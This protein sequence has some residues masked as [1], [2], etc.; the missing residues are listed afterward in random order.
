MSITIL[1]IIATGALS[2]MAFS[3]HQLI[4]NLVFY[5]YRIWRDKEWHR[6]VSCSFIHADMGHLFFNMF[7]L[8][9]FGTA[10]EQYFQVLF[11]SFG[12]TLYIIMY[13]G[14]VATADMYNLFVKRNDYMYRSLGASGGVS[15]IIFSFVLLNPWG[16]IY[17]F[18]IPIGIPA[19]VFGGLYLLYCVYMANRGGDNIGHTAHFTGSLFGFL[20][21]VL[22]KPALLTGFFQ[23]IVSGL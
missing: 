18:L 12:L 21:P 17:I 19:F 5:P 16:K 7:A 15:A 2:F 1:I 3:N 20:F 23:Q 11:P 14:A 9:S 4:D 22:F 6:L 8:Y 10:M 13:F